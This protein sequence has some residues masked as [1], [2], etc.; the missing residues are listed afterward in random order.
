M[1]VPVDR[2]LKLAGEIWDVMDADE[3][4]ARFTAMAYIVGSYMV[5]NATT[6]EQVN[7]VFAMMRESA[8]TFASSYYMTECKEH[9]GGQ[10]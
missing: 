9:G 4:D 7:D 10:A 8:V 5:M 3:W 6:P 1:T 2:G